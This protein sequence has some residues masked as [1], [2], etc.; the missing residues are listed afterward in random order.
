VPTYDYRCDH[1][2]HEFS[3]RQRFDEEP[4]A[5]C[6]TCGKRPRR[7]L[8]RPAIVFK[9]SGWHVTD[10]RKPGQTAKGES[11]SGAEAGTDAAKKDAPKKDAP[12][13]EAPE[14]KETTGKNESPAA[15]PDSAAS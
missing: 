13:K 1:C 6:P 12:K 5:T 10:Y 11:S 3:R 4:I 8:S 7:L 14:K 15:K 2:G 9:G